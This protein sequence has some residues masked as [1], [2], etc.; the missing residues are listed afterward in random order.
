MDVSAHRNI[1]QSSIFLIFYDISDTVF[2]DISSIFLFEDASPSI[3]GTVM[4]PHETYVHL[5]G[6]LDAAWHRGWGFVGC[7]EL[8]AR[9]CIVDGHKT[10]PCD[11]WLC[12]VHLGTVG[13]VWY[14]TGL[15]IHWKDWRNRRWVVNV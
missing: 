3:C 1:C 13:T 8:R 2:H 11:I 15:L 10:R 12:W 5:D 9:H 14:Q 4:K 7:E 6:R